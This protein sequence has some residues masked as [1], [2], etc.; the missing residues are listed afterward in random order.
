MRVQA[1]LPE[2]PDL[3]PSTHDSKPP[4]TSVPGYPTAAPGLHRHCTYI[5]AGKTT[6]HTEKRKNSLFKINIKS[7]TW[8]HMP[9]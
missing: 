8:W 3:I 9:L 7:Q 5:H 1:A 4:V 2:G 6:L